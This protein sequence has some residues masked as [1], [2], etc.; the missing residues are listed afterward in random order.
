MPSSEPVKIGFIHCW[1]HDLLPTF[2]EL[3]QEQLSNPTSE[4]L[5][6]SLKLRY[7]DRKN[8][9]LISALKFLIQP[10]QPRNT[11][12][13][14]QFPAPTTLTKF[15]IIPYQIWQSNLT[16]L[17]KFNNEKIIDIIIIGYTI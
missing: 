14:Y 7:H 15:L 6:D 1:C 13:P 3:K 11:T 4:A 2:L 9:I 12:R 16:F 5:L 17:I 8:S 10:A